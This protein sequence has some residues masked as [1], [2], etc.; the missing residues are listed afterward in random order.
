MGHNGIIAA[1]FRSQC[2]SVTA[3][4][5]NK[6]NAVRATTCT[7]DVFTTV[8]YHDGGGT[9]PVNGDLVYND[10]DGCNLYDGNDFFFSDDGDVNSYIISSVGVVSSSAVC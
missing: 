9:N 8:K 3:Y 4:N 10:V 1:A 6:G 5:S 2:N 7:D